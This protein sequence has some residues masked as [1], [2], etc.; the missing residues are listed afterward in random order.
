MSTL[1]A[2]YHWKNHQFKDGEEKDK[3]VVILCSPTKDEEN[4][5]YVL[6]TSQ[7]KRGNSKSQGDCGLP[8]IPSYFL[9]APATNFPKDTWIMLDAFYSVTQTKFLE[10][11]IAR[12]V[13]HQFD[14]PEN[15]ANGIRNCASR[16]VD[17]PEVWRDRIKKSKVNTNQTK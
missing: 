5:I 14:I 7:E 15:I 11:T 17:V 2:V 8:N 1:G 6:T 9:A 13:S 4:Y 12:E 10:K 16:S 3:Y